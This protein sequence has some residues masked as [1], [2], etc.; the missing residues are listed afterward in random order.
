MK[1]FIIYLL[2]ICMIITSLPY[3]VYAID[4]TPEISIEEFT[5]ELSKIQ[6]EYDDEPVSN[7]LIVK[8][9]YDINELD[10][11]D[12]VEG[13]E[14]LHI[15]QFD[16]PE[17]VSEALEYYESSKRIEYAEK[18]TTVSTMETSFPYGNHL[19]WG[20]DSIGVD[21]YLSYLDSF[22]SLPEIIVGIIDTG[23]DVDHEL[24]KDRIIRTYYNTSGTGDSSSEDDDQGH[25][26]HVAG[27]IA[28]N[29][30]DNVKIEAFKCMNSDGTGS[31]IN[32]TL[33]IY[34]AIENDVN[35][36]NMSIGGPGQNASMEEA[37]NTAVE[38]GI[39]VSVSAGNNGSDANKYHP[40]NIDACI[41]V[42]AI[43][44]YGCGPF[45]TNYGECVDIVAPGVAINSSLMDNKYGNKSGTSM[46]SPFVSAAAALL[47]SYNRDYSPTDIDEILKENGRIWTYSDTE[48]NRDKKALYIGKINS[49]QQKERAYKPTFNYEAGRYSE[50]IYLEILTSEENAEIYYTLDGTSATENTGTLY[51]NP[52]L[53]NCP[54]LV[55]ACAFVEGKYRSLQQVAQYYVTTLDAE[56]MFAISEDGIITDYFGN[57]NTLT[58]PDTV[59]N[60]TVRGIG[61][62]VFARSNI[63]LI[64]FPD[65]LNVV[66]KNAFEQCDKLTAVYA[67]NIRVIEDYG[68]DSC[69]SLE[70]IDLKELENV[71]KHAFDGCISLSSLYNEGLTEISEYAFCWLDG[72]I[73]ATF[74]NVKYVEWEGLSGLGDMIT[75]ALNLPNV[76]ILEP[77]ALS[78]G[79]F[80]E[81]LLPNLKELNTINGNGNQFSNC[82]ILERISIP[83]FEGIIPQ[84]AFEGSNTLDMVYS[85]KAKG[86]EENAFKYAGSPTIFAPSATF[87]KSVNCRHLTI[88]ATGVLAN[89]ENDYNTDIS[90]V[91]P[92][93]TY[94]AQW[95]TENGCNF[96][97]TD[98]LA[99]ALGGT[100]RLS[101][102]GLRFGFSWND[103]AELEPLADNVEYGFLYEYGE[104]TELNRKRVANNRIDHDGY[105]TF[106]LVF[107]NIPKDNY[108]TKIS[109]RAYVCIDGM[110]FYSKTVTRSF[111]S[112][113]NNVVADKTMDEA[114]KEQVRSILEA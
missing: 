104:T 89:I 101:D 7:R 17:S 105:T 23:I 24:L 28:D 109:A 84:Y 38:K 91:A 70:E 73:N 53:I 54:T 42:G 15:L 103:I 56:S 19:S 32:I 90:V 57:N 58:I 113:A 5:E 27:I 31:D 59:D 71:G 67:D 81:L 114:T 52:I 46:A 82:P 106:N 11:V 50:G 66:K 3:A 16:N 93:H 83:V 78:N 88:Y 98:N 69:S 74:T 108:D 55:H 110:Y 14:N 40:A 95:A 51:T 48:P 87:V 79:V 34:A 13:Y 65:T 63:F 77:G 36:I 49:F 64:K 41:T 45:W 44:E 85:P 26:T 100:I 111:E 21:D 10:S 12:V 62:G 33:A 92:Q 72:L 61:A 94:A 1:K 8:S 20:S 47:F 80:T 86:I 43:D 18:D 107:T 37:I 2:S 9:K 96:I 29:T 112:V 97:N 76:E 30:T 6:E 75:V 102:S 99:N 35:V 60:I 22:D 4:S 39:V 25:G 68:F